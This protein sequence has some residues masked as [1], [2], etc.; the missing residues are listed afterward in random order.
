[1]RRG[2]LFSI[3]IDT[4]VWTLGEGTENIRWEGA[5]LIYKIKDEMGATVLYSSCSTKLC[6]L[7]Y[8]VVKNRGTP[9]L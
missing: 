9:K 8:F 3:C 7:D 6:Y 4:S 5:R 2:S 1:M